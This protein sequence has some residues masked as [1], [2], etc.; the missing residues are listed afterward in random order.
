MLSLLI[1]TI[2]GLSQSRIK[3]L[4]AYSTI[5]HVG[6]M[7]L[8]LG[9]NSI[10]SSKAF[11]F[12]LMQ[13]TLSSVNAFLI[14]ISI[15]FS[16]YLYAN[17]DLVFT[18]LKDKNNSPIQLIAQLKGYYYINP[19]LA[20]SFAIAFLS[21]AGIPPFAGFFAK[22][23][24]LSSALENGFIFIVLISI[25]TSTIGGVYYLNIL[26]TLFFEKS[27]YNKHN[28]SV[29]FTLSS[30]LTTPVS[31]LTLLITLFILI[32]NEILNL[33]NILSIVSFTDSITFD[34]PM[35][36]PSYINE[37]EDIRLTLL[38]VGQYIPGV[39]P[40][41]LNHLNDTTI[42][43]H[44]TN[45]SK[46]ISLE[47]LR[48]R[49]IELSNIYQ[50]YTDIYNNNNIVN[51]SNFNNNINYSSFG[52]RGHEYG[53]VLSDISFNMKY[54]AN[55]IYNYTTY[56]VLDTLEKN[57]STVSIIPKSI[58][59]ILANSNSSISF[60]NVYTVLFSSSDS[61]MDYESEESLMDND[62][63]VGDAEGSVG[64]AEEV[65]EDMYDFNDD[66]FYTMMENNEVEGL[67]NHMNALVHNYGD[68]VQHANNEVNNLFTTFNAYAEENNI[69]LS[70]VEGLSNINNLPE[71][72]INS[73]H[74]VEST[75]VN[76]IIARGTYMDHYGALEEDFA[77]NELLVNTEYSAGYQLIPMVVNNNLYNFLRYIMN[78]N[79]QEIDNATFLELFRRG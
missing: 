67:R 59:D 4:L 31:I 64:D 46:Q 15:G 57:I 10:E 11:I 23:M 62:V 73:I 35:N 12:Y 16:L 39:D 78:S 37:E 77:N 44:I 47:E 60:N 21:F 34:S 61:D 36:T 6:F 74:S 70:N 45:N 71:N 43:T 55:L 75:L 79:L 52:H 48:I 30:Y 2:L 40:E 68:L 32:P 76:L 8:A 26:K 50:N 1:G 9:V 27:D 72:I 17:N 56:P 24:I 53:L 19:I 18:K 41:A 63:S 29:N 25:I 49:H 13:Y 22:F 33:G 54:A 58:E 66:V 5:S 65:V 69:D 20:V 7:L 14:L 42:T 51:N 28:L 3:R 38:L